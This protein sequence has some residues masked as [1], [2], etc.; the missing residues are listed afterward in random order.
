MSNG[1][2]P[3][4]IAVPPVWA[5]E[6]TLDEDRTAVIHWR[7][8]ETAFSAST[9][10]LDSPLAAQY[11]RLEQIDRLRILRAGRGNEAVGLVCDREDVEIILVQDEDRQVEL[12]SWPLDEARKLHK[13]LGDLLDAY[14]TT[15]EP[16]DDDR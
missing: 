5:L 12:V 6:S 4:R 8:G 9:G 14:D 10:K 15:G 7:T 11:L 3:A 2:E 13:A 1:S 16:L